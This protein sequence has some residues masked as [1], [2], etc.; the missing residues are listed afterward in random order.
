MYRG[1]GIFSGRLVIPIHSHLGELGAYCGRA[2]NGSEP[3]YRF[4]PGFATEILFNFH[5][6]AAAEKAAVI[7]VEGFFDCLKLGNYLL[8]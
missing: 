4:P 2:V 7:V 1:S 3:R 6:A 5:R 8:D